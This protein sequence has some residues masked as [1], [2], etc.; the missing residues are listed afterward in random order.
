MKKV[1]PNNLFPSIVNTQGSV[2]VQIVNQK[3]K[4]EPGSAVAVT[5]TTVPSSKS[6]EHSNNPSAGHTIPTGLLTTTPVPPNGPPESMPKTRPN[7]TGASKA[8]IIF[9]A[10][11]IDSSASFSLILV[12]CS[13]NPGRQRLSKQGRLCSPD[14]TEGHFGRGLGLLPSLIGRQLHPGVGLSAFVCASWP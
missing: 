8:S 10:L 4:T 14:Q 6:A 2:P 12:G 9:W 3:P 1:P 13:Q 11:A 5:V 7:I